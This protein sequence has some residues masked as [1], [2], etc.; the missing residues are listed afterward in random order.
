MHSSFNT[1]LIKQ[2][3]L[4]SESLICDEQHTLFYSDCE[5]LFTKSTRDTSL[6]I[7]LLDNRLPMVLQLI[8]YLL[9]QRS[10]LALNGTSEGAHLKENFTTFCN[11]IISFD[12]K[13]KWS[14]INSGIKIFDNPFFRSRKAIFHEDKSYLVLKTSGSTN[15][16]KFV[17]HDQS[18]V[19]RN[20]LGSASK[21]TLSPED[22]VLI[23]VPVYHSYGLTTALIPSII[24]G[25]SVKLVSNTN[26][27]RLIEAIKSF[28]PTVMFAT[29]SLIEMLLK[30]RTKITIPKVTTTA[31]DRL[32]EDLFL[33]YEQRIGTLLNLYGSTEMGAMAVSD[34][35]QPLI[36]RAKSGVSAL[37]GV[38]LKVQNTK[39]QSGAIYCK[40]E[41]RFIEYL[42]YDGVSIHSPDNI[43]NWFDTKDY[44]QLNG[45]EIKVLGRSD[46]KINRNGILLSYFE[47]ENAIA[48][49][50]KELKKVVVVKQQS[51]QDIMGAQFAIICQPKKDD[52]IID[53]ELIRRKCV[54]NLSKSM[55][56]DAIQLVDEMPQLAN[57]KID[58]RSLQKKFDHLIG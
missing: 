21:L 4:N 14:N 17:L 57:G 29:P 54:E 12:G 39:D 30:M 32:R 10:F 31:G 49:A 34:V 36:D 24:A 44:G 9:D 2:R 48:L 41:N 6:D 53:H 16:P 40:N 8:H 50:C 46:H 28:K 43:H 13:I 51:A 22:R 55:I 47:I 5:P 42:D 52:T 26:I 45:T 11:K 33:E 58:R 37:P 25:C 23:P 1:E 27:I 19:L 38:E 7:L 20:A 56:P 18:H 35:S 15:R 3:L